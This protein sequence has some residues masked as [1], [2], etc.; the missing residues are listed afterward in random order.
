M[1]RLTERVV[2]NPTADLSLAALAAEVGIGVRQL[3]RR[4]RTELGVT[5]ARYVRRVRGETA[6]Q[7]LAGTGS[8]LTAV[9]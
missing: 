6:A 8:P 4:F 3:D 5:P 7:L 2:A 9:A 1:T